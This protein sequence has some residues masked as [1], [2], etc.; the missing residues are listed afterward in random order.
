MSG[1]VVRLGS[2]GPLVEELQ[3][4]L[5]TRLTPSPN[6]V[7]DGQ[8]ESHTRAAVLR[9]QAQNWLVED[10]E[11][12]DATFNALR[13]M[14]T[15]SDLHRIRLIGQPTPT[16]CWA[17]STAMLLG[18]PNPVEA[19][20]F[21]KLPDGSLRND[22]ELANPVIT[23]QYAARFHLRIYPPMSWMPSALAGVL[24][25]GAVMVNVLWN[26]AAYAGGH[27]SSG[28][29]VVFAGI[30]GDGSAGAT[31]IRVYDPLPVGRGSIYS[32]SYGRMMRNVPTATYQLYQ[33]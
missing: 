16:S 2:T 3:R 18:L 15:Y 31:T 27:A 22:S 6:L 20:D 10:G 17:T 7:L 4:L 14:E 33:P 24:H 11:A 21:M 12:G 19:P 29:M 30:R 1:P 8:F 25:A 26:A 9:F 5:N 13:G 28:H 23:T 32:V